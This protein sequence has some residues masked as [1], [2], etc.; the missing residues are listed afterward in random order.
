MEARLR[1]LTFIGRDVALLTEAPDWKDSFDAEFS[2]L[3]T[4]EQGLSGRESRRA[5]SIELRTSLIFRRSADAE[6][7]GFASGLKQY[8]NQ[9]LEGCRS[10]RGWLNGLS[11]PAESQLAAS[12]WYLP[13]DWSQWECTSARVR[14]GVSRW[15]V[16]S[17][18]PMLLADGTAH[19]ALAVPIGCNLDVS[20]TEASPE[21][22]GVEVDDATFESW[23]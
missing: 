22:D 8:Q 11:V 10:G 21:V 2:L 13:G 4:Q 19:L 6:A 20:F 15:V 9:L 14:T 17:L 3:A 12:I 16:T 7:R 1:F 5:M 23:L 18:S